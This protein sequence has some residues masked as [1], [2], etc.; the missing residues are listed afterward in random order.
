[1]KV[2]FHILAGLALS[3]W[4]IAFASLFKKAQLSGITVTITSII[5]AIII[6][7]QRPDSASGVI[8]LA[9]FFPPMNY[10]LFIL[11]M[12]YWQQGTRAADLSQ[13]APN[14]PWQVAGYVFWIL[15][16]VQTILYP[17]IGAYLEKFLHGTASKTR[18]GDLNSSNSSKAVELTSFSKHYPP[19]WFQRNVAAR[20]GRKPQ[21]T[22]LAVRDLSLTV[23]KG[24]IM[25]LLGA[26]GS[27]KSTTLDAIAGL[28]SITSGS[29]E[30]DGAGGLG[31][32]PQKNVMWENLT[33][34]E[35]VK[36]FD[37]LK[38]QSGK[39]S[40]KAIADLVAA[41]DLKDKMN[42][43]AKT[44]SGGQ[45]RKLQLAM[46]FVGGSHVCCVDE[47][48]S[49]LDP[50][51]RRKI[52]DILL[53]E[54][55]RRTI[56]LTTHFLDE[57]DLLSDQIAMLSKGALVASGSAVE[58]KH[59]F[60]SGY[61][62]HIYNDRVFVPPPEWEAA[63]KQVLRDQTIFQFQGSAEAARFIQRL[64]A[65]GI[66]EY[67]VNGPTIEDVFLK[68][69]EEVRE[70]PTSQDEKPGDNNPS[71]IAQDVKSE[72]IGEKGLQLV[73]GKEVGLL[74]Q[75]WELFRKRLIVLR[76]NY[77]PYCAALLIPI[78]TAG[79]VTFFIQDFNGLS[80]SP[81]DQVSE[82][83]IFSFSF[84][85]NRDLPFGPSSLVSSDDWSRT[86]PFLNR[87]GLRPVESVSDFN[88]YIAANYS[89][90]APGGLFLRDDGETPLFAYRANF[91]LSG[92]VLTQN[93][94]D[95][96]L[97]GFPVA[98]SFR[99]F[100]L[101]FAPDAEDSLKLVLF[102]GLAMCAFPAFFALYPTVERLKKIRALHY[103]NGV[104]ASSLWLAYM[105]FDLIFI[106]IVSALTVIIFTSVS[107]VW[108][109]PGYL[110]LIFFLYGLAA[111][112][113]AYVV[114]LFTS[115]QLAAFA[116]TAGGHCSL[117]LI[118]FVA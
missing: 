70:A 97:L 105:C 8:L 102:F 73:A 95:N 43:K 54:R 30:Y 111:T 23:L 75:S 46:M 22:V 58:L 14:A 16:I 90:V 98:T 78:I 104:R 100:E 108:Y 36:I 112:L 48:S 110:F 51:S 41:C 17:I 45:K 40:N 116:F 53:S 27:G 18:R 72:E 57:A 92:A 56:L 107:G 44:L 61:R 25:V 74:R 109:Y 65:D 77:L 66:H 96:T 114:S 67:Q 31:L 47:V 4:S 29:I 115:S 69:A 79:L 84:F 37:R 13:S 11:Y 55:G 21:E 2:I 81:E 42:E 49:G 28:N 50:I 86:L 32:C 117:F 35:H 3:S 83:E 5:L 89:Q 1:M 103:S 62:V 85:T 26:N 39:S 76:R 93:L 59:R 80:C 52:W 87:S 34:F 15:L 88:A 91:D 101:P 9:L 38:T 19:S 82:S 64:E 106:L 99:I 94:L 7:V 60:G 24:Q 63:Q 10:T 118:Y 68:L 20:F 71:A 113:A 12:A 6:Q 33:V